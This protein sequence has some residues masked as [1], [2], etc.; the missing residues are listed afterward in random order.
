MKRRPRRTFPAT[1]TAL[2]MLAGCV[3]VAVVAVQMILGQAAWLSYSAVADALHGVRWDSLVL[4]VAGGF[5]G[6]L[7]LVL[8]LV[9]ILPGKPTVLPLRGEESDIDSGASRRS[10]RSTLRASASTVDGV[11]GVKLRLRRRK[12]RAEVKTERTVTD[13]LADAVRTAV[14]NRIGQI[15]PATP[16]VVKVRVKATRS[17]S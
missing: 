2:V 16:P 11:S 15:A 7:G 4:A 13:G 6:V 1:V 17:A 9:A 10:L 3:V 12:L 14:E 5:A 8:V